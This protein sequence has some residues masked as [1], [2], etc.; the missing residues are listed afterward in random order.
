MIVSQSRDFMISIPQI[1]HAISDK[2]SFEIFKLIS[3]SEQSIDTDRLNTKLK[4][5]RKQ[6]YSRLSDLRNTGLVKRRKG[7][8]SL[9][10]FGEVVYSIEKVLETALDSYWKLKAIDSLQGWK[11]EEEWN[12]VVDTLIDNYRLKEIILS[13]RLK[14]RSAQRNIIK[15]TR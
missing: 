13:S 7:K 11:L 12:K 4:F 10:S 1:L 5:T 15:A 9:T 6:F 3:R 14:Y 8:Y 2:K